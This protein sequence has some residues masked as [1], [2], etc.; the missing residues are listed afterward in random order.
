MQRDDDPEYTQTKREWEELQLRFDIT[1][2][3]AFT[4]LTDD[5]RET[6]TAEVTALN[7]ESIK[8]AL[9]RL[10]LNHPVEFHDL[11]RTE[12][13]KRGITLQLDSEFIKTLAIAERNA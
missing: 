4:S 7:T 9:S 2:D 13:E 5:E 10:I 11:L 3:G 1:L 6:L 12:R 8:K